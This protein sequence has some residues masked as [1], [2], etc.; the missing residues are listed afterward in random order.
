[1]KRFYS[2]LAIVLIFAVY[3]IVG[4]LDRIDQERAEAHR[5]EIIAAA[6]AE[7][8]RRQWEG[9][10]EKAEYLTFPIAAYNK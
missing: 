7:Y 5:A 1:M 3:G 10:E 2:A 8:K 4:T 9:L 6:K